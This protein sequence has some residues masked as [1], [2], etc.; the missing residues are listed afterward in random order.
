[1]TGH[2]SPTCDARAAPARLPPLRSSRSG[3]RPCGSPL[4]PSTA[5]CWSSPCTRRSPARDMSSGSFAGGSDGCET[6]TRSACRPLA[7]RP[8]PGALGTRRQGDREGI[9]PELAYL[10]AED[11]RAW[12]CLRTALADPGEAVGDLRKELWRRR[13]TQHVRR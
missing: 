10:L 1:M 11:V 8:Q 5:A 12:P 7:R 13:V 6:R 9:E 3:P 2:T 4:S